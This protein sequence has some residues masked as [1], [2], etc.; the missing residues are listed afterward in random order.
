V[1][2]CR[3]YVLFGVASLV[4]RLVYVL[5]L[6]LSFCVYSL[7]LF[8]ARLMSDCE[9]EVFVCCDASRDGVVSGS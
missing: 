5:R 9:C 4:G 3:V 6:Y 7:L 1:A 8:V 2:H